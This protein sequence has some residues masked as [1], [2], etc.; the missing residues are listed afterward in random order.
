MFNTFDIWQPIEF[1]DRNQ[2]DSFKAKHHLS[3]PRAPLGSQMR[4]WFH[5]MKNSGCLP[6][7]PSDH[8]PLKLP[9]LPSRAGVVS[10]CFLNRYNFPCV[11]ASCCCI[12]NDHKLSGMKHTHLS[13]PGVWAW[14]TLSSGSYQLSCDVV[15]HNL[16]TGVKLLMLT[17]GL[18]LKGEEC[19]ECGHQR[20]GM[21]EIISEFF[22][23]H[24]K[25][26]MSILWTFN[27][28]TSSPSHTTSHQFGLEHCGSLVCK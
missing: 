3:N 26:Q 13:P 8:S 6:F 24:S 10:S 23:P 27:G 20:T 11:L 21:L 5:V 4:I 18:M 19:T 12:T 15:Y 7:L 2:T 16:V 1:E 9:C 22:L 25:T 28:I 17:M 14:L